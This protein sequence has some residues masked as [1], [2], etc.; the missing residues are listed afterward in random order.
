MKEYDDML[1][2]QIHLKGIGVCTYCAYLEQ[3][4]GQWVAL[5]LIS[6]KKFILKPSFGKKMKH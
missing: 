1:Y 6:D 4:T 3:M 5:K 2:I